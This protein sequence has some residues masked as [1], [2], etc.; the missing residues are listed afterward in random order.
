LGR[1]PGAITGLTAAKKT[2]DKPA[3]APG[4]AS[5]PAAQTTDGLVNRT[6][7]DL[8]R[9]LP[10]TSTNP[11]T[12]AWLG[13]AVVH[14]TGPSQ[15]HAIRHDGAGDQRYLV[16]DPEL[17][18]SGKLPLVGANHQLVEGGAA[19]AAWLLLLAKRSRRE[20]DQQSFD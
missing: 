19:L 17:S 6:A 2:L 5:H 11:D 20:E 8:C 18:L 1:F 10:T 13:G 9:R 15:M 7:S 16:S 4:W 3:L 12:R 14:S